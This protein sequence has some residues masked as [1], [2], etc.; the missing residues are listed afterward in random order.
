MSLQIEDLNKE[1]GKFLVDLSRKAIEHYLQTKETLDPPERTPP[2]LKRKAG[3][4]VTL[5]QTRK[6]V[7]RLRGCIGCIKPIKPLVIAAID[8]AI[9]AATKDP[10]FPPVEKKE[11]NDLVI[12]VTVLTPPK[13]LEVNKPEE[14]LEKIETGRDGLIVKKGPFQGT[15]LPQVPV[16]YDWDVETFLKH[17]C[18]KA[19]LSPDCWKAEAEIHAYQGKIWKEKEPNGDIVEKHLKK[20]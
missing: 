5:N 2:I 3:I 16:H 18:R 15:L 19:G 20:R 14:Y 7:E 1:H 11:L 9:N 8:S 6:G 17:L 13:K 12:E 10:R 4:F